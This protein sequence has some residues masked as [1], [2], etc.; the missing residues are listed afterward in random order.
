M[1]FTACLATGL[2]L[3]S[4]ACRTPDPVAPSVTGC[5]PADGATSMIWIKA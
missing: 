4:F 5:T 1:K 2:V 3:V